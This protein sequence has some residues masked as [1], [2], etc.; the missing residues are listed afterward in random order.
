MIGRRDVLGALFSAVGAA[1]C[2]GT[3]RDIAGGER[4]TE[5]HL[6]LDPIVDL[7]PAAGLVWLMEARPRELLADPILGE[8]L[9][10]IATADRFE[11]LA[12]R[13]GG[14]DLRQ[15]DQVAVAS[16]A[17]GMRATLGLALVHV[18]P[19]RVEAAFAARARNVEGR[20]VERGVTRFWGTVG[21]EREQVALFGRRGVGI[22]RG[23]LGPLQASVYFAEGRLKRARPALRAEPLAS[24]AERLGDAPLR[25]FAPGPFEGDWARGVG[26]LLRATTAVGARLRSGRPGLA[27]MARWR[28]ASSWRAPGARTQ[29]R[30]R[31]A[32][33]TPFTFC[34]TTRLD[35]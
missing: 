5:P 26:G 6:E 16:T 29:R 17:N 33:R 30:P 7:V 21:E 3:P 12:R 2:G 25:G 10:A 18:E 34:P 20:A 8:T 31:S 22:E 11:A 1:A 4:A 15:A 13:H 24:V 23:G 27:P 35:D 14:V 32:W 19:G 9:S 28:C